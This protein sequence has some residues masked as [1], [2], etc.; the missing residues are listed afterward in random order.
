MYQW[1][2]MWKVVLA[3]VVQ[4]LSNSF[5]LT[6]KYNLLISTISISDHWNLN[7]IMYI[8]LTFSQQEL[9]CVA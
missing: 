1:N 5:V 3:Q 9:N 6:S 4:F 2:E 7:P 8:L